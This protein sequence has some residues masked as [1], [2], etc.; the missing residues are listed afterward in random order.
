MKY[1]QYLLKAGNSLAR[2]GSGRTVDT[3]SLSLS[4]EPLHIDPAVAQPQ[5]SVL[6]EFV[7]RYSL[8]VQPECLRG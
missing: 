8:D 1:E 6:G 7:D 3:S 2:Q 4:S 5:L